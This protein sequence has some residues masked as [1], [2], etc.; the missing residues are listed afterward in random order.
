MQSSKILMVM[1]AVRIGF[2]SLELRFGATLGLLLNNVDFHLLH[3]N[4]LLFDQLELLLQH[5]RLLF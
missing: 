4:R 2:L 3:S 1:D 5:D